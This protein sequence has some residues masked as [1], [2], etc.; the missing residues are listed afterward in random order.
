MSA[1]GGTDRLEDQYGCPWADVPA[2]NQ[3]YDDAKE[4]DEDWGRRPVDYGFD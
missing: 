3:Q 4:R 2:L 1:N